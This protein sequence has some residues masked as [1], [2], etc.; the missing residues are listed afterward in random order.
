MAL[1]TTLVPLGGGGREKQA[2]SP[3]EEMR[4]GKGKYSWRK[5]CAHRKYLIPT[6]K[7]GGKLGFEKDFF[8]FKLDLWAFRPCY[9]QNYVVATLSII[10][11][12][13]RSVLWVFSF[14]FHWKI[15]IRSRAITK[16][17]SR[18]HILL[19]IC[20]H[21]KQS[22]P[23]FGVTLGNSKPETSWPVQCAYM[24]ILRFA[25]RLI[26]RRGK[27]VMESGSCYNLWSNVA[28]TLNYRP[29]KKLFFQ[30]VLGPYLIIRQ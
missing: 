4:V 9:I 13:Y 27:T 24:I 19:Y 30:K 28:L 12:S 11:R 25:I 17:V 18:S 26:T 2:L 3:K 14:L 21:F 7:N 15:P 1:K 16:T 6:Q 8:T 29:P 10:P 5:L 20:L 22:K 23:R